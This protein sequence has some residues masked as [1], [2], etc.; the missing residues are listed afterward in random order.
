MRANAEPLDLLHER[1]VEWHRKTQIP[2]DSYAENIG[3]YRQTR[4]GR[5]VPLGLVVPRASANTGI[6]GHS[7]KDVD[8]DHLTLVKPP[9]RNN[10]VYAGVLRFIRKVVP[11]GS[12]ATSPV[13]SIQEQEAE[14]AS[15]LRLL[16]SKNSTFPSLRFSIINEGNNPAQIVAIR[17]IVASKAKDNHTGIEYFTGIRT[18]LKVDVN[19]ALEGGK[20]E[21]LDERFIFLQPREIEALSLTIELSNVIALIDID[22][23]YLEAGAREVKTFSPDQVILAHS[24]VDKFGAPGCFELID[25]RVGIDVLCD[26]KHFYPWKGMAYSDC[27]NWRYAMTW[28]SGCFLIGD[29]SSRWTALKPL[30]GHKHVAGPIWASVAEVASRRKMPLPILGALRDLISDKDQVARLGMSDDE[31]YGVIVASALRKLT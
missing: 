9:N 6:A 21:L 24:P 7:V 8:A 10:D 12:G 14:E 11:P 29:V 25:R 3:L 31:A 30:L 26:R 2:I 19:R 4:I 27:Q 17:L 5:P 13:E 1:F 22:I 18:A 28:G 16:F 20:I 23:A 15:P